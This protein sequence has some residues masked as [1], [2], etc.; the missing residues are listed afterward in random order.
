MTAWEGPARALADTTTPRGSH[1]R[2]LVATTPRHLLVPHWW[3]EPHYTAQDG[4]S[5]PEAWLRAAYSDTSLVTRAGATHADRITPGT[6][7]NPFKARPTSSS[8]LPSLV[9]H[10]LRL[11]ELFEGADV[12]DVGTGSGYSAALLCRHLGDRRVTSLDIDPYLVDTAAERLDR[13]GL[14]PTLHTADAGGPIPGTYDAI[15]AMVAVRPIPPT[16][17]A[18][19]RPGGR[20][21]TTIAGTGLLV[22]AVK[23]PDGRLRGRIEPQGAGFMPARTG[24][25]YPAADPTRFLALRDASPHGDVVEPSPYPIPDVNAATELRDLLEV[26]APGIE[27]RYLRGLPGGPDTAWMSH[28]DGSWARATA[29]PGQRPLVHQGGPRRL[30]STLD[31]LRDRWLSHGRNP[32]NGARVDIDPDGVIHLGDEHWSATLT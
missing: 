16:W 32:L 14:R 4:P 12:L 23:H 29:Y 30:W 10:L 18:A 28:H 9:V 21:V 17:P 27:H 3:D 20:L 26:T 13:L 11:A 24:E 6:H 15:V 1:W 31:S 7:L 2:E 19:L 22:T 8:T 25:D 5:H